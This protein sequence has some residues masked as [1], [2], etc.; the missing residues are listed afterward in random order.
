MMSITTGII[1][2]H[3]GQSTIELAIILPFLLL[4]A[5]GVFEFA[6]AIQAK[7]ITANMSREGTNLVSRSTGSDTPQDIMAALASTAQPLNMPLNGMMYITEFIGESGGQIE[8]VTQ[9]RWTQWSQPGSYRHPSNVLLD[10]CTPW[11][12]N[13][14]TP[15][16]PKPRVNLSVLHLQAGDLA[17][18][19]TAYATEVFYR[20]QVI[21]SKIID[22]SPEIYSITVF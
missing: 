4:L 14:C 17:E 7:N 20:Q 21:F 19:Q 22:Y 8:V 12:N 15:S 6:R 2:D 13:I 9:Y 11:N 1:R 16:F 18:G 5:L 3:R 10:P